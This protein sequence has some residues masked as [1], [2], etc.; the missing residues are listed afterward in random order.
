[1]I[2]AFCFSLTATR[3]TARRIARRTAT[4]GRVRRPPELG[5]HAAAAAPNTSRDAAGR[6][7]AWNEIP[8]CLVFTVN[9]F[10]FF[11]YPVPWRSPVLFCQ[12]DVT[13]VPALTEL[14]AL[15]AVAVRV[16]E[17]KGKGV[18]AL[19]GFRAGAARDDGS[20]EHF[21]RLG[22]LLFTA[23]AWIFIPAH[24]CAIP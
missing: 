7:T 23:M 11:A 10:C 15:G 12:L 8:S 13:F 9:P 18:V 21:S 4:R 1:M 17:G 6:G 22:A 16:V 3:S 2:D 14:G 20:A 19:R 24:C 5:R